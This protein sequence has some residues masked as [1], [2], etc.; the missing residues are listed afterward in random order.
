MNNLQAGPLLHAACCTTARFHH[1]SLASAPA[2]AALLL[3]ALSAAS[4]P[5]ATAAG[6]ATSCP[7]LSTPLDSTVSSWMI[8]LYVPP[9]A[10]PAFLFPGSPEAAPAEE[11]LNAQLAEWESASLTVDFN[12]SFAAVGYFEYVWLA[13]AEPNPGKPLGPNDVRLRWVGAPRGQRVVMGNGAGETW[14][15]GQVGRGSGGQ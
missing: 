15:M 9:A 10:L 2:G 3:L 14:M 7:S 5:R 1:E 13:G 6:N 11:A 4:A 8:T 12:A